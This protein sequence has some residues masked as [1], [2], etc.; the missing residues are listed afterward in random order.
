MKLV[1]D[2]S[3]AASERPKGLDQLEE[4][5]ARVLRSSHSRLGHER[6][7]HGLNPQESVR[8]HGYGTHEAVCKVAANR[9]PEY[10]Y[11]HP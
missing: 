6:P 2:N 8:N 9:V 5:L 1:G 4:V 11:K 3:L 7:F 10:T